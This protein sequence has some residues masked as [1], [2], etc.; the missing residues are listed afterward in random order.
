M[1]LS[2]VSQGERTAGVEQLDGTDGSDIVKQFRYEEWSN[3]TR[4]DDTR[5]MTTLRAHYFSN[6]DEAPDHHQR[7]SVTVDITW[8]AFVTQGTQSTGASD[9]LR[10]RF[11][12]SVETIRQLRA[13]HRDRPAHLRLVRGGE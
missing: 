6:V 10:M 4:N 11:I 7:V 12:A 13:D 1:S 5:R 3:T 2:R 8:T 9:A